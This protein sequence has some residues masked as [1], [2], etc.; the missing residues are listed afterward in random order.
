MYW[1]LN[2]TG[3][4]IETYSYPRDMSMWGGVPV[5]VD[6]AF[7]YTDGLNTLLFINWLQSLYFIIL[8]NL[9]APV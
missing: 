6:S 1:K 4:G 9:E 8:S 2:E 3:H 5:P 7:T